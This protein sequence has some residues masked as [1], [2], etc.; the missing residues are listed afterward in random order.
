MVSSVTSNDVEVSNNNGLYVSNMSFG[1][2]DSFKLNNISFEAHNGEIIGIYGRIRS[3]KTT[4]AGALSG[5]YEYDGNII[6]DGLELKDIRNDKNKNFIHYAPGRV[7]IFNDTI[8]Y[9]ITFGD[10][11]S[12]EKAVDTACLRDDI[13]AF[14]NKDLEV[15]SHS[16]LNISGGQQRRLQIARCVFDNPRLVILDDPF[17]AI[18]VSMSIK[19]IENLKKNYPDTIFIIINNQSESLKLFDKIIYLENNHAS[20]DSYDSLYATNKSFK[21]LMGGEL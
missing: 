1:Y 10:E 11:G 12:Y 6:L 18:G 19:I 17:N 2:D 20:F 15:L 9:N 7:E 3:G 5:V 16:L 8:K 14:P 21:A 4:L 13:D